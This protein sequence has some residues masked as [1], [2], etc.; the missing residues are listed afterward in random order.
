VLL[1]SLGV[2]ATTH[3]VH[4]AESEDLSRMSLAELGSIQ[5]TSVSKSPELLREAPAAIYVITQDDIQRSG[6]T[7]WGANAMNG[8]INII[9]RPAYLTEGASVVARA[10]DQERGA[11]ARYGAKLGESAVD[12][13]FDVH[14]TKPADPERIEQL[15]ADFLKTHHR[16]T[17]PAG[18]LA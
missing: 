14:M 17:E 11:S 10:G 6:A 2:A 18:D 1:V 5:V 15:L 7:L 13:G 8:V 9:T 4:S 3:L 12:A 16:N